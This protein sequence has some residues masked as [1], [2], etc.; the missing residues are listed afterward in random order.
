MKRLLVKFLKYLTKN[1]EQ[2]PILRPK[3][4]Q[5]IESEE[6]KLIIETKKENQETPKEEQ[7]PEAQIISPIRGEEGEKKLAKKP[8]KK[9]STAITKFSIDPRD[10]MESM[11]I[12][13]LSLSKNRKAPIVYESPDGTTK[14]RI[15]CHSEHY[16]ASIYDW[17]IIQCIAGKIQEVINSKKDIPPRTLIIPRHE[18]FKGIHKQDGKKQHKDLEESLNRLQTTLI[19]TTI[20]NED[21]RYRSGFSF[22][23]NWR[24]TERKDIKEFRITLSEWLYDGICRDGALLKVQQ[25]YFH[26]TS[27][28]QKVLYRIA[29][30]HVGIQNKS[31]DF[32]IEDLHK[33]SG[34]E[35][36]LRKF[37]YDLKKAIADHNIPSYHFEWIEENC[38]ITIRIINIRKFFKEAL[39]QPTLP[40]I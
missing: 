13:F 31:W 40:A 30:K 19:D 10:I 16:I 26:I 2:A 22:L 36:D 8:K 11:G 28:L 1:E 33:K 12:P 38:K 3:A 37:K 24:Y 18:L 27:G 39:S 21:Y 35:R 15:S 6:N 14:V 4:Q 29:R 32:S 5:E 20:R 34:S 17:D 9:A 7:K 23:D 25:E